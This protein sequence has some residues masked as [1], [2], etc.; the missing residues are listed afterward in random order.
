MPSWIEIAHD[1][2]ER[3]ELFTVKQISNKRIHKRINHKKRKKKGRTARM[4][5]TANDDVRGNRKS[6]RNV[7]PELGHGAHG[8]RLN[9]EITKPVYKPVRKLLTRVN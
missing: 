4:R 9:Y 8:T 7:T 5:E 6:I 1:K 2:M 3:L